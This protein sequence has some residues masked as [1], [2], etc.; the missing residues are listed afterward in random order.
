MSFLKKLFGLG[1]SE[2]AQAPAAEKTTFQSVQLTKG[3]AD[4]VATA[5][6]TAFAARL[7]KGKLP[8]TT[9]TPV[10][11]ANTLLINGPNA[12]VEEVMKVIQ[13]LDTESKG[14]EIEIRIYK[15][16]NGKAK[17]VSDIIEQLL[18]LSYIARKI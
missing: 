18:Q 12:E 2:D 1:G 10:G 3:R 6:T 17:E 9:V 8:R 14:H 7:G 5:V 13:S 11:G 16:E 15:L 4:D